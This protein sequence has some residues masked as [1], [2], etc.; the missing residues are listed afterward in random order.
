ME[1]ILQIDHDM[2]AVRGTV[3]LIEPV[4]CWA[5]GE[6]PVDDA[7]RNV[8][9]VHRNLL[10]GRQGLATPIPKQIRGHSQAQLRAAYF[11]QCSNY[12]DSIT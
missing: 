5:P 2:R 4:Q 6:H 8:D 9:F 1:A 11:L 12:T 3:D 7:S 10:G